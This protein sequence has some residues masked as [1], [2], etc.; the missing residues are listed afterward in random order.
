[1]GERPQAIHFGQKRILAEVLHHWC[2]LHL[3]LPVESCRFDPL[4]FGLLLL[5]EPLLF[6]LAC[7]FVDCSFV[8]RV[9][10]W[11]AGAACAGTAALR[12]Y[13]RL[14]AALRRAYVCSAG[15]RLV[16]LVVLSSLRSCSAKWLVLHVR[17]LVLSTALCYFRLVLSH[18]VALDLRVEG[19]YTP[20]FFGHLQVPGRILAYHSTDVL[21]R[22][23]PVRL[24]GSQV[25]GSVRSVLVGRSCWR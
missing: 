1:M 13:V 11:S 15:C 9:C 25:P 19:F 6:G 7:G 2:R 17:H 20:L 8:S 5:L 12:R 22:R 4:N 10:L 23:L 18:H 21:F 14:A 3:H 24:E 16:L